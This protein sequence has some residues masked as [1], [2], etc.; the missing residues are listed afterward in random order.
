MI[1]I[2]NRGK[3]FPWNMIIK[4]ILNKRTLETYELKCLILLNI[5]IDS[6]F[7]KSKN[8]YEYILQIL[9]FLFF[10]TNESLY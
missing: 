7:D 8:I 6:Y 4:A 5:N 10:E 1:F 9:S 3:G 2:S